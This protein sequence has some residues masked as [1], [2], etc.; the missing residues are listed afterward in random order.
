[1]LS[2]TKYS[3]LCVLGME[4][5]YILCVGYGLLLS[6]EARELHHRLF[7]LILGF[8]WTD[9]LRMIWGAVFL[10]II[11]WIAGWYVAWMHNASVIKYA[12]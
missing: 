10:G 5:F 7:E 9:P 1:M 8:G 3:A 2:T 11:A 12:K 6:G 4:V